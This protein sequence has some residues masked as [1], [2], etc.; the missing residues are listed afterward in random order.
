MCLP[1]TLLQTFFAKAKDKRWKCCGELCVCYGCQLPAAMSMVNF[2]ATHKLVYTT[3]KPAHATL[4][5]TNLVKSS[6]VHCNCAFSLWQEVALFSA[7]LKFQTR[8]MCVTHN[9]THPRKPHAHTHTQL[10]LNKYL[11]L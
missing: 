5:A 3:C 1:Q 10:S 4:C 6:L 11:C 2:Y 7:P 9:N 8:E